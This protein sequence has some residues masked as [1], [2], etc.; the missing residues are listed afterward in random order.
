M[1]YFQITQNEASATKRRILFSAEHTANRNEIQLLNFNDISTADTYTITVPAYADKLVATT[2]TQTFAADMATNLGTAIAALANVDTCTVVKST[3][4][5]YTVEFTG[6]SAAT[7]MPMMVINVLAA[8]FTSP[9]T[10]ETQYGHTT[11]SPARGLT[12]VPGTDLQLSKAGATQVLAA[13]TVV[14][15]GDGLYYYQA[16]A[17]DVDTLG[18]F[19]VTLLR[20]DAIAVSYPT[21]QIMEQSSTT[22]SPVTYT[23]TLASATTTTMTLASDASSVTDKYKNHRGHIR[24]GAGAGEHVNIWAYNGTT[25]VCSIEPAFRE[26]PTSAS[27]VD[28][29]PG[30]LPAWELTRANHGTA[31]TF[32]DVATVADIQALIVDGDPI[33]SVDGG[34]QLARPR[35]V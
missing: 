28:I 10:T 1:F 26:T 34:V 2:G 9:V 8:S 25:K 14:E 18:F 16:S 33:I 19:S 22:G 21:V 31:D 17:A 5:T 15:V 3:G 29:L 23:G 12:I 7:D 20:S 24:T 6:T 27:V 11:G 13:G 4:Q 30:A 32:G 35:T